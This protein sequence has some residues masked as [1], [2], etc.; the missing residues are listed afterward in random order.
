VAERT[1]ARGFSARD[2][3]ALA[4]VG[5]GA[6]LFAEGFRFTLHT[7]YV[8][9]GE[10]R[11]TA[12]IAGL[13]WFLRL[14][15]V[16][17]GCVGGAQLG[18]WAKRRGPGGVT[19]IAGAVAGSDEVGE[20]LSVRAALLRSAGALMAMGA[21]ASIG[22][23]GPIIQF[24]AALGRRF[25]QRA[26]ALGVRRR[27]LVAAGTAAG[28]AAAY[29]A[30]IAGVLFVIEA[31]GGAPARGTVARIAVACVAGAAVSHLLA[32]D[33]PLYGARAFDLPGPKLLAVA[34][35]VGALSGLTGVALVRALRGLRGLTA[36]FGDAWLPRA[37]AFGLIAGSV[38]AAVPRAAGN[39][40]DGIV[41]LLDAPE[42]ASVLLVLLVAKVVATVSAVG[43]GAP[44]GVFTPTM[45]VG[46]A[47][48]LLVSHGARTLSPALALD[49]TALALIGMSAT[50][51]ATTQAP[52]TAVVLAIELSRS[53]AL[54]LPLLLAAG[55]A[56][57]VARRLEESSVYSI[58]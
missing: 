41:G 18:Q 48:G 5:I 33:V 55:L 12:L 29:N 54:A 42:P 16:L 11:I 6:A 43:S 23:E 14:A 37:L 7:G 27:E 51:A 49:P 57:L 1:P 24:G 25:G 8:L 22:R 47:L 38:I 45:F 35:L 17:T 20:G 21:G 10:P 32:P 13:P 30:P 4:A 3:A 28:F 52:L 31:V 50:I 34:A 44:G 2:V 53:H 39:G 26:L 9:A 58:E 56:M 36:R 40:Y 19:A 46:A 15:L